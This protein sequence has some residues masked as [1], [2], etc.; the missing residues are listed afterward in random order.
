[1]A[2]GERG[3]SPQ[4][5]LP[6]ISRLVRIDGRGLEQLARAVDDS[7]LDAG[8]DAGIEAHRWTLSGGSREQEVVQIPPEYLDGFTF[9]LL[10]QPLL[11]VCRQMRQ[12][13]DAPGPAHGFSEPG[14]G[15]A[16]AILRMPN[17]AAI[18]RSA[19]DAPFGSAS[20][21]STMVSR[22]IPSLRP[23]SSASTRCDGTVF[24]VSVAEK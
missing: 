18:R 3:Q 20:V 12:Q 6:I 22:R 8:T 17:L 19:S 14:V 24:T 4:R 1:M 10:A 9:G 11:D 2:G 5:A 7:D 21:G 16:A 15:G 13:L 23:R